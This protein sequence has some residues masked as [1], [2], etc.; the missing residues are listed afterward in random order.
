MRDRKAPLA[1]K[2]AEVARLQANVSP[3]PA[4]IA[5]GLA[6]NE[7]AELEA[8][9]AT[10]LLPRAARG[11]G[12]AGRPRARRVRRAS[13]AGPDDDP[14][15]GEPPGEIAGSKEGG[16]E[17][18]ELA[19]QRARLRRRF[20]TARAFLDAI[21]DFWAGN[22]HRT[23]RDGSVH[24]GAC[25]AC[26]SKSKPREA[27]WD[28][29]PLCV[30]EVPAPGCWELAALCGCAPCSILR[31]LVASERAVLDAELADLEWSGGA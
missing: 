20:P 13:R 22:G 7:L 17:L 28:R 5:L 15:P 4:R 25:P 8:D 29:Y 27:G 1:V 6:R 26:R 19:R 21:N 31:A 24:R 9:T 2:R 23:A 10:R 3:G 12:P 30:A 14:G 18:I 16:G 11:R